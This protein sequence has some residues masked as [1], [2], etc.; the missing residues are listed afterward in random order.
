MFFNQQ[1]YIIMMHVYKAKC[2]Q[3]KSTEQYAAS[4]L[5]SLTTDTGRPCK[6]LYLDKT[7]CPHYGPQLMMITENS[8]RP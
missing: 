8:L 3:S 2:Q 1:H 5:N 7:I 6:C 4:T